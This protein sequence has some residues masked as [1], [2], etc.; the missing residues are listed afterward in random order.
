[1]SD[2]EPF[3]RFDVV[4]RRRFEIVSLLSFAAAGTHEGDELTGDDPVEVAILYHFVVLILQVIEVREV[5]PSQRNR[6]FESFHHFIGLELV[7]ARSHTCVT[8][9]LER[10]FEM[11]ELFP[12][13]LC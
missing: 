13:C 4:L 12:R 7:G 6:D 2:T 3:K 9:V 10:L 1:M 8:E 11:D 5:V